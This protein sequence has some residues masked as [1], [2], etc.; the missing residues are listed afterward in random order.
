MVLGPHCIQYLEVS[1]SSDESTQSYLPA[2]AGDTLSALS[3]MAERQTTRLTAKAPVF[4]PRTDWQVTQD[5]QNSSQSIIER[6]RYSS[7]TSGSRAMPDA[8]R[9]S[10]TE[11]SNSEWQEYPA[12]SRKYDDDT[13]ADDEGSEV[14]SL[15]SFFFLPRQARA[16]AVE[17]EETGRSSVEGVNENRRVIDRDLAL[18]SATGFRIGCSSQND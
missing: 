16:T 6:D 5:C 10:A 8:S 14:D 12:T 9:L 1:S 17:S 13:L 4:V 11:Y 2:I 18:V 7:F 15:R 3:P